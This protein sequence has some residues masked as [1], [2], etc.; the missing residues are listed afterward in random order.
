[1]RS[2][3]HLL[4]WSGVYVLLILV[5]SQLSRSLSE[6][7]FF[8]STLLPVAI[9]SSYFFNYWLVPRYLHEGRYGWFALYTIYMLVVSAYLEMALIVAAFMLIGNYSYTQLSPVSTNIY[10]LIFSQY[11]VVFLFSFMVLVRQLKQRKA[12]LDALMK[13][14]QTT[15]AEPNSTNISEKTDLNHQQGTDTLLQ[16][17]QQQHDEVF[18]ELRVDRKTILVRIQDIL[19]IESMG[20]YVQYFLTEDRQLVTKDRLSAIERRL[21]AYLL[22]VHRSFLVNK[23][24]IQAIESDRVVVADRMRVPIGR[25]YKP[26]VTAFGSSRKVV[27]KGLA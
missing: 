8:V 10:V 22:R 9:G 11:F 17:Q 18:T 1:M 26:R 27:I 24:H 12:T 14:S 2:Y 16:Q 25:T 3:Q 20:D 13:A 23:G 15:K 5:Y 21:E 4:F 6:S 7:L 19:Y